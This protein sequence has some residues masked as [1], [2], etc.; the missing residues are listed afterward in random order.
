MQKNSKPHRRARGTGSIRQVR[1]GVWELKVGNGYKADGK[2]RYV[3]K[4]VHGTKLEAERKLAEFVTNLD[5]DKVKGTGYTVA[6]F[7]ERQFIPYLHKRGVTKATLATYA[8]AYEKIVDGGLAARELTDIPTIAEVEDWAM[9]YTRGAAEQAVKCYRRIL[10]YAFKCGYFT[11]SPYGRTAILPKHTR[12]IPVVWDKYEVAKAVTTMQ[13]HR[14]YGYVL[15][16]AG[17]GC[18]KEE[19]MDLRLEKDFEIWERKDE[20]IVWVTIDSAYTPIDGQKETK[21]EYSVRTVPIVG[22]MAKLLVDYL[23]THKDGY[24]VQNRKGGRLGVTG[25][26][27]T[28]D[29]CFRGEIPRIEGKRGSYY[30]PPAPLHDLPHV[31]PNKLRHAHTEIMKATLVSD[32]VLSQYHG[33]VPPTIDGRVYLTPP[34]RHTH[35]ETFLEA[36][37]KVDAYMQDAFE[38]AGLKV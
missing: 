5:K 11:S 21:N 37:R 7:Y 25:L 33:H 23:R 2:P 14:L 31:T 16:M 1:D 10:N 17:C 4:T 34:S 30:R 32:T 20:T 12:T 19:A 6:M 3:Y 13:G 26:R 29:T 15:V 24:L 9:E 18:R 38:I 28:W 8:T 27:K 36:A 35:D 22:T